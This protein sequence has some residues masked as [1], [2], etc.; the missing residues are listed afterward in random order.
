LFSI[1]DIIDLAIQI[2]KNGEKRYRK[3]LQGISDPSLASLLQWLADQEIEHA[4]WFSDMRRTIK[5][6]VS[7]PA[8]AQMGKRLLQEALGDQIFSL[9]D[10]DFSQVDHSE[11]LLETAIEF[12]RDTLL[13]YQMMAS[14]I[15]S[16][17]VLEHLNVI[18][19]E[20]N[21]H[22]QLLEQTLKKSDSN[23]NPIKRTP[24]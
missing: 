14:F 13:F 1:H 22:I 2:E 19:E 24:A 10:A 18:I 20:E 16:K 23:K 4:Q 11:K 3:A 5:D 12:E 8:L 9:K 17:A 6:T 15:E 21:R 7:D